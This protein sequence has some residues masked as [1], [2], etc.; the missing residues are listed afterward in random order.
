MPKLNNLL[1]ETEET[2]L[3]SE[4]IEQT[5]GLLKKNDSVE[6]E[7]NTELPMK[8]SFLKKLLI[9]VIMLTLIGGLSYAGWFYYN[10]TVNNSP[11]GN[12]E[13]AATG[14]PVTKAPTSL[15]LELQQPD[16]NLLTFESSIIISGKTTANLPVVISSQSNDV[17][18]YSNPDGKFSTVFSLDEGVN[19][20]KVSVFDDSGDQKSSERVVYYSP[21]KI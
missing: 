8:K 11:T 17:V 7:D 15:T 6:Q 4:I 1:P 2:S 19:M 16:D 21:D 20:I 14:E 5:D 18:I 9:T 3:Q 10:S 13:S 12:L